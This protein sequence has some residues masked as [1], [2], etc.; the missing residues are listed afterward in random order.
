MKLVMLLTLLSAIPAAHA[1]N[2]L[3]SRVM[4][5]DFHVRV[6]TTVR[7]AIVSLRKSKGISPIESSISL[8]L[9]RGVSGLAELDYLVLNGC[10]TTE[11]GTKLDVSFVNSVDSTYYD[12]AHYQPKLSSNGN[13]HEGNPING[14]CILTPTDGTM[15]KIVN[16][17]S[18]AVIATLPLP[19]VQVK[20]RAYD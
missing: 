4:E 16:N 11:A 2:C 20:V 3:V 5:Q 10:F 18:G 14:V 1:E 13:D 7:N 6:A 9:E 12:W 17:L 8:E 15:L 19:P